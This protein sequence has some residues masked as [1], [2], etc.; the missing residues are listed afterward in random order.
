MRKQIRHVGREIYSGVEPE[1][2]AAGGLICRGRHGT[3]I[4]TRVK[5]S[6]VMRQLAGRL[7]TR[8][9]ASDA[10]LSAGIVGAV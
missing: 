2:V 9:A 6:V 8:L 3:F 10:I 1:A 4:M 5:I 7:A